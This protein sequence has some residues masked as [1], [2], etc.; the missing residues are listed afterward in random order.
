MVSLATT[1]AMIA[2]PCGYALLSHFGPSGRVLFR[3]Y[4]PTDLGE[5]LLASVVGA[6][7]GAEAPRLLR[8]SSR[9]YAP[10]RLSLGVWLGACAGILGAIVLAVVLP[11]EWLSL[12]VWIAAG[13][14]LVTV[15]GT[16]GGLIAFKHVADQTVPRR[17]PA[18]K[19]ALLGLIVVLS[20]A[21][22][23]CA[24]PA[25]GTLSERDAWA[26]EHVRE[27]PGLVRIV[28]TLPTVTQDLGRVIQVAP[29]G[30]DKHSFAREMN[31]DDLTFTLEVVGDNGTGTLRADCTISGDQVLDWRSGTWR[32]NGKVTRI[33]S[34]P[35]VRR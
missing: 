35:S 4:L 21:P 27:Y 24:F 22:Q 11:N 18:A 26:R 34:V 12:T 29:T 5:W 3:P 19:L 23:L 13:S 28:K 30:D 6:L 25:R 16:G 15:G 10:L 32:F 33:H 20:L 2:L 9:D 14:V 7:L 17:L 8:P 1:A 31:G